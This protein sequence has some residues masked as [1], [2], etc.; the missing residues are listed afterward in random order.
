MRYMLSLLGCL[1]LTAVLSAQCANGSCSTVTTTTWRTVASPS[2]AS[3]ACEVCDPGDEA[4][5]PQYSWRK[6]TTAPAAA[7]AA[8]GW[9]V[10]AQKDPAPLQGITGHSGSAVND[11][12][13]YGGQPAA[14]T[15]NVEPVVQS[16]RTATLESTPE[17]RPRR[18]LFRRR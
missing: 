7:P 10:V 5:T 14:R 13:A 1:L 3:S 4:A 15:E 16:S 6:W 9:R 2:K 12:R 17:F 8:S 11:G 18:G